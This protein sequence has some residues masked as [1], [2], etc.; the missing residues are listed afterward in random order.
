VLVRE[1]VVG[2]LLFV[3]EIELML[4]PLGAS[5]QDMAINISDRMK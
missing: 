2:L 1:F 5:P 3:F 4:R